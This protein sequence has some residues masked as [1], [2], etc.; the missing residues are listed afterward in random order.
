MS[1]QQGFLAAVAVL[2][3]VAALVYFPRSDRSGRV[4]VTGLVTLDGVPLDVIPGSGV[5]FHALEEAS[6]QGSVASGVIDR[7]GRYRVDVR[8]SARGVYPGRYRV[9]VQG[10]K[11]LPGWNPDD[12]Y[13]PLPPSAVPSWYEQDGNCW[14]AVEVTTE[15]RQ[16]IDLPLF[17]TKPK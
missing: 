14:P 15:P 10:W 16:T 7:Q 5:V 1:R 2:A 11:W 6:G 8:R 3:L 13:A 9:G 4:E 12:V 17:S